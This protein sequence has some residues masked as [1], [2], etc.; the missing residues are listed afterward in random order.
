MSKATLKYKS[1]PKIYDIQSDGDPC[2]EFINGLSISEHFLANEKYKNISPGLGDY[3]LT[4]ETEVG[5]TSELQS[6][7]F[8]IKGFIS[9]L[10]RS[11]MYTC[12]H[13]LVKKV[14][15][16]IGPY[17]DF[18]DGNIRGWESNFRDAERELNKGKAH[19]ADVRFVNYSHSA[20]S[21][22]PLQKALSTR[23]LYLTASKAIVAL[24]DLHF[25][26]TK[27]KIVIQVSCFWQKQWSLYKQCCQ[28]KLTTRKK[29]NYPADSGQDLK[30]PYIT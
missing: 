24:V 22:W 17:I 2:H 29:S 9:E 28:G 7:H 26:H 11:W 6:K 12:G 27:L 16:F 25:F 10:D 19:L 8:S 13:P 21:Y 4:I 3:Y 20:F 23:K 30:H 5:D 15:T 18:P 14:L 1:D